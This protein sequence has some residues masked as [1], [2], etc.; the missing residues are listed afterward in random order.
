MLNKLALALI[1]LTVAAMLFVLPIYFIWNYA[2]VDAVT[3]AKKIG[4]SEAIG[5]AFLI[6]MLRPSS[7]DKSSRSEEP[8][9]PTPAA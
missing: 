8:T 6:G 9:P 4:F 1:A 7:S 3:W 2:L 5:I